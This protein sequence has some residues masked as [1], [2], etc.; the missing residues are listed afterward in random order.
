[1]ASRLRGPAT[2]AEVA[3]VFAAFATAIEP[4]CELV[5]ESVFELLVAVVLSAQCTDERV[6]LT[7]PALFAKYPGA[8]AFAA[9]SRAPFW[10]AFAVTSGG[11]VVIGV[12]AHV[13]F[14]V[15]TAL[16]KALGL[17]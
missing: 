11:L 9:A 10:R 2:N 5:H 4:R 16:N 8:A 13:A 15:P 12:L 6:N 7:T 14:R 1:M 3:A 17:A